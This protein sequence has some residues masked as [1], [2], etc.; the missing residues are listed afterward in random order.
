MLC[1]LAECFD[2]DK[3][4][5]FVFKLMR[6]TKLSGQEEYNMTAKSEFA[7]NERLTYVEL[8]DYIGRTLAFIAA[9]LG[10]EDYPAEKDTDSYTFEDWVEI[11]KTG[12]KLGV[13]D[14]WSVLHYRMRASAKTVE[15]RIALCSYVDNSSSRQEALEAA[16]HNLA[17]LIDVYN[18]PSQTTDARQHIGFVIGE[19]DRP[20]DEW[21]AVGERML[22]EHP[23]LPLVIWKMLRVVKSF[24]QRRRLLTLIPGQNSALVTKLFREMIEEASAP[25]DKLE[26]YVS[27][28]KRTP[29]AQ[30]TLDAL[31]HDILV[32][33]RNSPEFAIRVYKING[34]MEDNDGLIVSVIGKHAED[35]AA[36]AVMLRLL[37]KNDPFYK[38]ILRIIGSRTRL[39]T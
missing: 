24:D 36:V 6:P 27:I 39:V 1:L 26:L 25:E 7:K 28:S 13:L 8:E 33:A 32:E 11:H 4:P 9:M 31:S 12:K 19:M 30:D 34:Q 5:V 37:D 20:F 10:R 16:G 14:G 29:G 2:I 15:Q 23:L 35:P 18:I 38:E 17:L 3:T 21:F 22:P